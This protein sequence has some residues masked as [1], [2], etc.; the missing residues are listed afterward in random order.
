M[1]GE[2]SRL[3]RELLENKPSRASISR[4]YGTKNYVMIEAFNEG[5]SCVNHIWKEGEND[6]PNF[7]AE[8]Y[9]MYLLFI[10][11]CQDTSKRWH[12]SAQE[13]EEKYVPVCLGGKKSV[14]YVIYEGGNQEL[15]ATPEPERENLP[16]RRPSRAERKRA[17]RRN[18]Q[19]FMADHKARK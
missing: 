7:E 4:G 3:P 14:N 5:N 16:E 15:P 19:K 12:F 17:R 18:Y 6:D 8:I 13:Y 1:R 2:I 9:Q 10:S 11:L